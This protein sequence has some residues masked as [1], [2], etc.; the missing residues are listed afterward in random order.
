MAGIHGAGHDHP[1]R[2]M[3]QQSSE[4]TVKGSGHWEPG[5]QDCVVCTHVHRFAAEME[6]PIF[7]RRQKQL[8]LLW[9]GR[10]EGPFGF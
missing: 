10:R 2:A 6:A 7:S 9:R 8:K 4:A 1:P 5:T 3:T